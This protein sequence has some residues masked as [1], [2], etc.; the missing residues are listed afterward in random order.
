MAEATKTGPFKHYEI[1]PA[2]LKDILGATC[3]VEVTPDTREDA[4]TEVESADGALIVIISLVGDVE[5]SLCIGFP[6]DTAT[7]LGEKFFGM[8]MPFESADLSDCIGE[9][10]NIFAGEIKGQLDQVGITADI[11]LPSVIRGIAIKILVGRDCPY[12]CAYFDTDCGK[13][14]YEVV[15]GKEAVPTRK[16]GA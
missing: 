4:H 6:R 14:W 13:L 9:I 12:E 5:W 15:S 1:I 3:G 10:G 16:P 7:G 8:P 2:S 11:S